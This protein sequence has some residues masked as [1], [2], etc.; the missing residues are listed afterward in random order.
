MNR[1]FGLSDGA[2]ARIEK[3]PIRQLLTTDTI[4]FKHPESVESGRVQI[5]SVAPLLADAIQRIHSDDS[6]SELFDRVW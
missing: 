4:P 5:I 1:Y 2:M 3:S 6:V